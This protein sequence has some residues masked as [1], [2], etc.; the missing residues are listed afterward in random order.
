MTT[1]VLRSWIALAG[2]GLLGACATETEYADEGLA[3]V[4]GEQ[5]QAHDVVIEF[6]VCMGGCEELVEASCTA[7]LEGTTLTVEA[8]ATIRSQGTYCTFE[9]R[10]PIIECQTPS[11]AP[12]TYTLV[13]ADDS[14]ELAVPVDMLTC[15]QEP[16]PFGFPE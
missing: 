15:T 6:G 11:L 8:T 10:K 16:P 9:C 5:G 14:V 7:T 12:G 13:Y 2:M 4:S 1:L 3:C